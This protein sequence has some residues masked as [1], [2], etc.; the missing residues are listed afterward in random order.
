MIHL[1]TLLT[2]A[3]LRTRGCD[4]R[5]RAAC[6]AQSGWRRQGTSRSG[7]R[8]GRGCWLAGPC[9]RRMP[10]HRPRQQAGWLQPARQLL[11]QWEPASGGPPWNRA[12]A[13][14]PAEGC[15]GN[16]CIVCISQALDVLQALLVSN[17]M[18]TMII[19][20]PQATAPIAVLQ[21]RRH[22]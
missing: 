4:T 18:S 16:D 1:A 20:I 17:R 6:A 19:S 9:R 22:V 5:G 13:L 12:F 15:I 3:G 14:A 11:M 10:H 2:P 8:G 7:C 21:T